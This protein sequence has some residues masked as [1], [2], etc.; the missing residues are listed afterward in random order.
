MGNNRANSGAVWATKKFDDPSSRCH[1]SGDA[2]VDGQDY[3]LFGRKK[4]AEREVDFVQDKKTVATCV[5]S[6]VKERKT[7]KSPNYRG[8][9]TLGDAEWE[10][11][12]WAKVVST[13]YGDKK[14]L[15]LSFQQKG[16]SGGDATDTMS[17]DDDAPF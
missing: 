3:D 16:N 6:L 5:M 1:F 15:S 17:V 8:T 7:D 11:A 13:K 10:V 4:D 14:M 9:V 2:L 12:G